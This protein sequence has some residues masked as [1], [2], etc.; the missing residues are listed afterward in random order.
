MKILILD[1]ETKVKH[2]ISKDTSGGYGT[3][4]DFGDTIIPTFLKRTLKI[5]HDWAPMF[6]VYTI[7]VLKKYGHEVHYSKIPPNDLNSFDLYIVVSSIVCCETECENI[8]NIV[9][10]NKKVFDS[11]NIKQLLEDNIA[12]YSEPFSDYSSLPTLLLSQFTKTK[13]TVALSG[14]GGDELFYGYDRNRKYGM[15]ASLMTSSIST[16]LYRI[17]ESKLTNKPLKLPIYELLSNNN[18][19][20]IES[21]FITGAKSLAKKI[22]PKI[23]N[24]IYLEFLK[25]KVKPLKDVQS[26]QETLRTYEYYYHLQRILIKV[27]RASMFHSLEVRVPL[28]SN[29]VIETSKQHSFNDCVDDLN[30][31]LPLRELLKD[32]N[33]DISDLPKKGFTFSIQELIN[34]DTSGLIKTY[35]FK[36][37][38]L[39]DQ[40][41]DLDF[42]KGMYN[43]H[44]AMKENYQDTSWML[45]SIFTLKSWYINHIEN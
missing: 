28:L 24:N 27:D 42:I 18:K 13:A 21:N 33:D 12:A 4:N 29:R 44:T 14:D 36:D 8:K 2:R 39:L 7:S 40:F 35:I 45:W 30:G 34:N 15:Q 1:P 37:I 26:F 9:K 31:K 41:L 43:E 22:M 11:V 19:A 38:P 10:F 32:K 20:L 3:G 23:T 5:V 16:K 17:I 6:A 25:N